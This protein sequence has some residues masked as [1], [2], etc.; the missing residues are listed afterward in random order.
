MTQSFLVAIQV[1]LMNLLLI[2]LAESTRLILHL[3]DTRH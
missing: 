3:R 2:N 1:S